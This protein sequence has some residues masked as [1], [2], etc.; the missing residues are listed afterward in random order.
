MDPDFWN[1]SI[2]F[3]AI[4]VVILFLGV[5]RGRLSIGASCSVLFW[6]G[7]WITIV[8]AYFM[9]H[10]GFHQRDHL[11]WLI[12]VVV[13]IGNLCLLAAAYALHQDS[14]FKA[15]V[16]EP[17]LFWLAS[18][19]ALLLAWDFGV[20]YLFLPFSPTPEWIMFLLSPGMVLSS[21]STVALGAAAVARFR[22]QGLPL[23]VF[24]IVYAILQSPAYYSLFV[25]VNK[26]G[27]APIKIV[28]AIGKVLFLLTTLAVYSQASLGRRGMR[29]ALTL[30][31]TALGVAYVVAKLCSLLR[32]G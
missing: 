13:D 14:A 23:L 29:M 3:F 6:G 24:C 2:A 21:V 26:P 16:E 12:L 20:G 28:L 31:N 27:G 4:I 5:C 32:A 7:W 8:I 11:R 10:Y 19:G 18:G 9:L 22:A 15:T 25:D 30:A 17:T 1:I